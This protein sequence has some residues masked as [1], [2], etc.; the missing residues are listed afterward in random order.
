VYCPTI[1]TF[2]TVGVAELIIKLYIDEGKGKSHWMAF[3][4]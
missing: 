2:Y 3:F 4:R 1:G